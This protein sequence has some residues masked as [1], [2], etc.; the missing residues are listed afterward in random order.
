MSN[1]SNLYLIMLDTQNAMVPADMNIGHTYCLEDMKII[2][3]T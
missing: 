3:Q 2:L 1:S